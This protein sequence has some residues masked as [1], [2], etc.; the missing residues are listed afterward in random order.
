MNENTPQPAADKWPRTILVVAIAAFPL[1]KFLFAAISRMRYPWDLE[2]LECQCMEMAGR[3]VQGLPLYTPPT[4]RH[5]PL[6]YFPL[7]FVVTGL[8]YRATGVVYWAGR[9]V[10]LAATVATGAIVFWVVRRTVKQLAPAAVAAGL[11][12]ATYGFSGFFSD[13]NR[14]DALAVFFLAAA[15]AAA[16]TRAGAGAGLAAGALLAASALTKQNHL[17]FLGPLVLVQLVRGDR[18]GALA[19]AAMFVAL[20]GGV[21]LVWNR[22]SDGWLWRMTMQFVTFGPSPVRIIGFALVYL[23][24]LPVPGVILISCVVRLLRRRQ[25][26]ELF[27]DPW[28]VFW[29]ASSAISLTMFLGLGAFSNAGMPAALGVAIA[30]G[31]KLPDFARRLEA[32]FARGRARAPR[33]VLPALAAAIVF[34]AYVPVAGQIPKPAQW[35]AAEK[36][37]ALIRAQPGPVLIP[38]FMSTEPNVVPFHEMS[39]FDLRVIPRDT[40]REPWLRQ[41]ETDLRNLHPSMVLASDDFRKNRQY[42]LAVAGMTLAPLPDDL[43]VRTFTGRA[44]TL[45]DVFRRDAGGEQ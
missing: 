43:R 8:L 19:A 20:F 45:T 26:R 15:A 14:V 23:R 40:W 33:W 28:L 11:W 4:I 35:T 21:A 29:A 17:L 16:F 34:A 37:H 6:P 32:R 13:L 12:F 39:Y 22:A 9:L 41:V 27:G 24:R 10:S 30:T 36:L 38:E 18:R 31:M 1:A 44:A 5:A 42:H 2:W 7:Y 25:W 3:F